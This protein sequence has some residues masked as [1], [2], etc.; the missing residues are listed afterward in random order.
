MSAKMEQAVEQAVEMVNIE[1]NGIPLKAPKGSMII[2]ATDK[3][4]SRYP[5]FVTTRS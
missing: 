4:V 5:V 2:E 3:A 1:V